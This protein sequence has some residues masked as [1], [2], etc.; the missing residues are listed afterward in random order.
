MGRR[1]RI[2][3]LLA[4]AAC[5]VG[6]PASI[7]QAQ[8]PGFADITHPLIGQA[9]VGVVTIEGSASHPSFESY[10]LSFAYQDRESDTWF[11]IIDNVQSPVIDGRLGI[12]DTTSITDGDYKLRLRVHLENG[13]ALESIVS[14]LRLRNT[15]PVET[16]TAGPAAEPVEERVQAP[17]S[18]PLPTPQARRVSNAGQ[19]KAA[20]W[21]G[22]GIGAAGL[23]L[24]AVGL[25]VRRRLQLQHASRRMRD[26]HGRK[27]RSRRRRR[28]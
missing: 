23:L 19:T 3:T 27:D 14:G 5:L 20:L 18:T 11:L 2:T 10:D 21:I 7:A 1:L 17:T 12:W 4:V 26:V 28:G 16:A 8:A 13:S 9:L 25:I 6:F 24:A 22:G 15:T